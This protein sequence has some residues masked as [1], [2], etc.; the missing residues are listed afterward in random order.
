MRSKGLPRVR[1]SLGPSKSIRPSKAP[2]GSSGRR[3]DSMG[4]ESP[5]RRRWKR[6]NRRARSAREKKRLNR[7]PPRGASPRVS[8]EPHLGFVCCIYRWPK[9]KRI[10]TF[11]EGECQD[12]H[13]RDKQD[14]PD[15]LGGPH[16][17]AGLRAGSR[18]AP[19]NPANKGRA[20]T[21][22]K[23]PMLIAGPDLCPGGQPRPP[24]WLTFTH[25][26]GAPASD[27]YLKREG[28]GP[29]HRS[30]EP[31]RRVG[32]FRPAY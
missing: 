5:T 15:I 19:H 3:L 18:G 23:Q 2:C 22:N 4:G 12:P 11:P 30:A 9:P 20:A 24:R 32:A 6:K 26:G 10:H 8:M 14:Q 16:G 31:V 13:D 29:L 28:L 25:L 17:V 21:V 7:P 1:G 27:T